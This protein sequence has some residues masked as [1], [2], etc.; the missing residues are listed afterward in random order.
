[1]TKHRSHQL[2]HDAGIDHGLG[3]RM[4]QLIWRNTVAAQRGLQARARIWLAAPVGE[5]IRPASLHCPEVRDYRLRQHDYA[6]RSSFRRGFVFA[7]HDSSML[8]V[9]LLPSQPAD[10]TGPHSGIRG[11]S[12]KRCDMVGCWPGF[13]CSNEPGEL[14]SRKSFRPWW[15]RRAARNSRHGVK[16]TALDG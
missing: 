12:D 10:F 4:A 16:P 9:D 1:M 15:R 2:R 3:E 8:K 5:N 7:H 11:E 6:S 13:E 14:R